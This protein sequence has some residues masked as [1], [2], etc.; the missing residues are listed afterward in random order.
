MLERTDRVWG[1]DNN[2]PLE[3]QQIQR[4]TAQLLPPELIG[5]HIGPP[6]AHTTGRT[7]DLA[8][9]AG[10]ALFGHLG[11]E[12]DLTAASAT[13]LEELAAWVALYKEL[14][15]LLHTGERRP[16]PDHDPAVRRARRGRAGRLRRAVRAGPADHAGTS[17]P[18]AVRLPGLDPA[19]R[20]RVQLQPPGDLPTCA[21]SVRRRGRPRGS[22]CPARHWAPSGCASRPCFPSN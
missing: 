15:A 11:I 19:R 1:C 22:R 12:W 17:V 3:R 18:G 5:S 13:E 4:W 2:D 21:E 20:Y 8:F 10:T 7:H 6:R 9:R 14:R 16:R